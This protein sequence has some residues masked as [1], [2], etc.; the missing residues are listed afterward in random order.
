[1]A[2]PQNHPLH[3]LMPHVVAPKKGS[4]LTCPKWSQ[5]QLSLDHRRLSG[6]QPDS[7]GT[8]KARSGPMG[9]QLTHTYCACQHNTSAPLLP[10][11]LTLLTTWLFCLS[12]CYFS[13]CDFSILHPLL[14]SNPTE[15]RHVQ[16]ISFSLCS[17]LFQMP[18]TVLSLTTTMITFLLTIPWSGLFSVYMVACR[19]K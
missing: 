17:E 11:R 7:S 14:S 19:L 18:L 6:R 1:M 5:A 12:C 15:S 2:A 3:T 13:P 16:F 10:R 4:Q 9:P 8:C